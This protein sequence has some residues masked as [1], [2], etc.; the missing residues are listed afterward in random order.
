MHQGLQAPELQA[1]ISSR[2]AH[3]AGSAVGFRDLWLVRLARLYG[4]AEDALSDDAYWRAPVWKRV[5][6]I[7]AG[8]GVNLVFAV[9][10]L[11]AGAMGLSSVFVLTNALR[12]RRFGVQ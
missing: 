8:P 11:A 5:A 9:A 3:A 2:R 4:S 12:L 10:L 6:V 1:Y 7:F